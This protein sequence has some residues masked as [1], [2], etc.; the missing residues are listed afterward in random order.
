MI[1]RKPENMGLDEK[2]SSIS[3]GLD[4]FSFLINLW[5]I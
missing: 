4:L 2:K 5:R 1:D 3:N